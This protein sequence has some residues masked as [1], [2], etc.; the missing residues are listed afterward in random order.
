[1]TWQI[2][3]PFKFKAHFFFFFLDYQFSDLKAIAFFFRDTVNKLN[4]TKSP[5]IPIYCTVE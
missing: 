1:M 3:V 5:S 4:I 2:S